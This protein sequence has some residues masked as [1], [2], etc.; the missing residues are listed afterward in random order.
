VPNECVLKGLTPQFKT[1]RKNSVIRS[2]A[3]NVER[4]FVGADCYRY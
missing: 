3:L 1:S 4:T 2:P